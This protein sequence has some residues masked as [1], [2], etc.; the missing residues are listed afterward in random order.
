MSVQGWEVWEN[1]GG[2]W[3]PLMGGPQCRVSILRNSRSRADD[4]RFI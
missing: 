2:K 1:V 4:T 3:G